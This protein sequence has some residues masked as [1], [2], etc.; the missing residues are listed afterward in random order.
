[1]GRG[2]VDDEQKSCWAPG[3]GRRHVGLLGLVL[4]VGAVVLAGVAV[5]LQNW[6]YQETNVWE[7][8]IGLF[9]RCTDFKGGDSECQSVTTSDCKASLKK[10]E[11]EPDDCDTST[12]T[13][14]V[15]TYCYIL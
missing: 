12:S 11:D 4:F 1:M 6:A 5:G 7:K 3:G 2:K 13:G 9:K 10:E 8:S 15:G 14:S